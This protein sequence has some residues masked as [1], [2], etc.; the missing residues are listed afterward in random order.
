MSYLPHA[1]KATSYDITVQDLPS[2]FQNKHQQ[3][4]DFIVKLLIT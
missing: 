4:V 2:H 1:V 3:T